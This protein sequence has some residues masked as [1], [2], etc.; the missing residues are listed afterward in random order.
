MRS[1]REAYENG[2]VRDFE[3]LNYVRSFQASSAGHP[4]IILRLEG[5]SWCRQDIE[6]TEVDDAQTVDA[7]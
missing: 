5:A 2:E 6:K 3:T 1:F 4:Q 7:L